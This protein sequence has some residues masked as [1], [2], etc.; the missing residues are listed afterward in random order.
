MRGKK[1]KGKKKMQERSNRWKMKSFKRL[2]V[3][4]VSGT[5]SWQQSF[6]TNVNVSA[7]YTHSHTSVVSSL[8]Q[9]SSVS[10]GWICMTHTGCCIVWK[11]MIFSDSRD[12]DSPPLHS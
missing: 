2:K 4:Y 7:L 1:M 5:L 11:R 3:A 9:H 6:R 10:G 12:Y 8:I